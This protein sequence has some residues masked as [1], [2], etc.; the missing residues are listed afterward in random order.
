MFLVAL[1]LI[2]CCS[3]L[4]IFCNGTERLEEG[5]LIVVLP[6]GLS[7]GWITTST[8]FFVSSMSHV[9]IPQIFPLRFPLLAC[10]H[11]N[12]FSVISTTAKTSMLRDVV[13][14]L[15]D[16]GLPKKSHLNLRNLEQKNSE[17]LNFLHTHYL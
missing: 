5:K 2:V 1:H 14:L 4:H 7:F 9:T 11:K 13:L 16:V 10:E 8:S 12:Q 15:R 17:I 6:L 3:A